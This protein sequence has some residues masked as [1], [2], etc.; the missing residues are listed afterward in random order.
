MEQARLWREI[1]LPSSDAEVIDV[2]QCNVYQSTSNRAER[3]REAHCGLRALTAEILRLK[4]TCASAANSCAKR[5]RSLQ[6]ATGSKL[7]KRPGGRLR[8]P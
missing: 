4:N 6:K 2:L 5:K 1:F 3:E 8:T 7:R